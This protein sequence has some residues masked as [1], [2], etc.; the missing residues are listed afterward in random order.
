MLDKLYERR[1]RLQKEFQATAIKMEQ[2]RGA[3]AMVEEIIAEATQEAQGGGSD[4]S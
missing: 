4:K 2:I 1:E 3:L